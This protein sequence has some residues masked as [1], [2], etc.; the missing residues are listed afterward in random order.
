M[1]MK[2]ACKGESNNKKILVNSRSKIARFIIYVQLFFCCYFFFLLFSLAQLW[3]ATNQHWLDVCV[4]TSNNERRQ[5][6]GIKKIKA[7]DWVRFVNWGGKNNEEENVRIEWEN[8]LFVFLTEMRHNI[9]R[10]LG[11]KLVLID[12][13]A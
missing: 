4:M 7:F 2:I 8:F 10:Y 3:N 5:T 6:N 1:K 13:L 11:L 9:K 12:L